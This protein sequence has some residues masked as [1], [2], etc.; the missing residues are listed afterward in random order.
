MKV[1]DIRLH[2]L[3]LT[4]WVDP[5]KTVDRVIV[6]NPEKE[7]TSC[8]VTWIASL[9]ACQ[10]AVRR[11]AGLLITHEPTFYSHGDRPEEHNATSAAQKKRFIED[12][13]LAVMRVHDV[14]DSVPGLGVP[15]AWARFLGF[16]TT[17]AATFLSQPPPEP[18]PGG[19]PWPPYMHRYD[20][21]PIAAG[22]LAR[23]LAART[24]L[25]GEPVLQL[26]GDGSKPVSRIGVGTGYA[27]QPHQFMSIGCD[28]SVVCDDGTTF[29]RHL[30]L[31]ADCGHPVIRVNHGTSEEP[32]MA[33]LAE[34]INRSL[35]GVRAEHLPHR[36]IYRAYTAS[37]P[38]G[39]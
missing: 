26:I 11:R 6:G 16:T 1:R 12:A 35:P 33:T 31:A 36:A 23:K 38:V 5:E 27:C 4:P 39:G 13:G 20:I 24:A 9:E 25:L 7:V 17:P 28:C 30:Q 32:A 34:Y 10:E 29:W 37:G 19:I 14:W 22:E 21:A 15:W 18:G 3:S 2:L 8:L